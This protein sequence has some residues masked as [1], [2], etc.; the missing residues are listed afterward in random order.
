MNLFRNLLFWIALILLGALV[1]QLF[2]QDPGYVLVR[3]GGNDYST[4]LVGAVLGTL[5]VLFV[6]WLVWK[7]LTLP[8]V[9]DLAPRKTPQRARQRVG[10]TRVA[11]L[12]RPACEPALLSARKLRSARAPLACRRC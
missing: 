5:I 7:L 11:P 3:Y 2:V 10:L 6:L 9:G 1:A 8:L 12:L 4:T